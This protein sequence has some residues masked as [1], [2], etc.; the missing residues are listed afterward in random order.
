MMLAHHDAGRGEHASY[1]RQQAWIS[2]AQS[3]SHLS[4]AKRR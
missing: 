3:R 2:E 4:G 1:I